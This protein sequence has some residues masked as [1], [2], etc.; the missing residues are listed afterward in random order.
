MSQLNVFGQELQA[1]SLQPLTGYFR[2]G[3]CNTR[4]D[5]TGRHVVCVEMT[6]VFLEF[7]KK[8][9]NDLSTP[10]PEYEFP[11][12]KAGDRWCLCLMRWKEAMEAGCAPQVILESTHQSALKVV[13][14][15]V[16]QEHALF[17]S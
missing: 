11:G 9:G 10:Q 7:S 14:L 12:L 6:A 4:A 15:S 8:V 17:E 1:C 3:C 13:P 2:D 16:F 5:D